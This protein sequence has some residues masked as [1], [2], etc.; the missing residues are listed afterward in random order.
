MPVKNGNEALVKLFIE[1]GADI[2][3]ENR[4]GHSP[5][6]IVLKKKESLGKFLIEKGANVNKGNYQGETPLLIACQKEYDMLA[7]ILIE[8]GA[9]VNKS[10]KFGHTPL[11]FACY[12]K[13]GEEKILKSLN[14][15]NKLIEKG[16]DIP[17]LI[18][19]M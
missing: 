16:A 2:N 14:I 9:D 1:H 4:Y 12:R 13:K 8:K 7:H 6:M 17:I 11:H 10:D 3:K 5:L 19:K 18:R 15:L